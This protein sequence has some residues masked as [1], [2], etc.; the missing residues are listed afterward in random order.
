MRYVNFLNVAYGVFFL[1]VLLK[2]AAPS[3]AE[4]PDLASETRAAT[5]ETT[6]E[7]STESS[8]EKPEPEK[9]ESFQTTE[10]FVD[11]SETTRE[12][13]LT[14]ET[15]AE[16]TTAERTTAER[17]T[18][19]R[20]NKESS[21][22]RRRVM[23]PVGE[24]APSAPVVV[25]EARSAERTVTDRRA[26]TQRSSRAPSRE[27]QESAI[28]D[29]AGDPVRVSEERR[30][31]VLD[32]FAKFETEASAVRVEPPVFYRPSVGR[33]QNGSGRT[34]SGSDARCT[35]LS[36]VPG[37]RRAIFPL[38]AGYADSYDDTWGA[39]RVQG[40]HEGTDLMIPSGTPEYAITGGTLVPVA[41]ANG[42]GWNTLGG[43]TVMLRADYDVGPI[44]KGDLF[45]YAH[46]NER[47]TLPIGT[48][49]RAG[50]Q[51]GVAGD[52]GQGPEVTRGLF[53]SHLHLGWYDTSGARTNLPSGA[54]NPYPLL[55]WLKSNGGVISGG[56]DTRYCEAPQ[57]PVPVPS[58][59]EKDWQLPAS[60]GVT[61]D[62]K[63]GTGKSRPSPVVSRKVP[64]ADSRA[65]KVRPERVR[66]AT[67][68]TALRNPNISR[69]VTGELERP[70]PENTAGRSIMPDTKR[71][72]EGGNRNSVPQNRKRT[73]KKNLESRAPDRPADRPR[74]AESP[75]GLKS[76]PTR[77]VP[78]RS[79]ERKAAAKKPGPDGEGT[80]PV[81][82]SPVTDEVRDAAERRTQEPENRRSEDRKPESTAPSEKRGPTDDDK[83]PGGH[84]AGERTRDRDPE[85]TTPA[86]GTTNKEKT[87]DTSA[88]KA[89]NEK[90]GDDSLRSDDQYKPA[91]K[92]EK[93]ET[94]AKDA[95]RKIGPGG[96]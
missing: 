12:Q 91:D 78:A 8:V 82:N 84:R 39:P 52:T 29:T 6:A 27:E 5:T 79:G 70:S 21:S 87:E 40:G 16:R 3:F 75:N 50:Q 25:N 28:R 34:S 17:T 73:S 89:R 44:R 49:V 22:D 57:K 32:G 56:T 68:P 30:S 55:E 38:P 69:S 33:S 83:D 19:E 76:S 24:S 88:K 96:R 36:G 20:T 15:T 2:L 14:E 54:M 37:N 95:R 92:P 51:I 67:R 13:S 53:P 60:P 66:S 43:Y 74:S 26:T 10:N 42:R 45:Y 62:L 65:E 4:P 1:A 47:G 64:D 71:T 72:S 93:Y 9:S 23:V 85:D 48:R 18:A 86:D 31:P 90:T 58:T 46:M 35:D 41:G 7:T 61:P 77:S 11:P 94:T 59:G 63:T 80:V 81:D